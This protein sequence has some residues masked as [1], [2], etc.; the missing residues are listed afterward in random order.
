MA[1]GGEPLSPLKQFCEAMKCRSCDKPPEKP[2]TLQC[3]HTFCED[4]LGRYVDTLPDERKR[5]LPCPTCGLERDPPFD[6]HEGI[7]AGIPTNLC[8]ANFL[9]HMKKEAACSADPGESRCDRCRR[10][11]RPVDTFCTVCRCSLCDRCVEDHQSVPDTEDHVLVP[12]NASTGQHGRWQCRKHRMAAVERCMTQ[13]VF[14]CEKCEVVM[15]AASRLT[16]HTGHQTSTA[17]DAYTKQ[18]HRAR[19]EQQS[20]ETE[21][22]EDRFVATMGE[23]ENLK[24]QLLESK[25][26]TESEIDRKT[27]ALHEAL[28][29]ENRR[30]KRAA[31][32]IFCNKTA[33]CDQ[34]MQELVEI[35]E[36]FSH[37]LNITQ[38]ALQVGEA[39][40]VLFLEGMLIDSLKRLSQMYCNY[41]HKLCEDRI[42][43]FTENCRTNFT[44]SI[45]QVTPDLFIPGLHDRLVDAQFYAK[46]L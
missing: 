33:K 45:G 9:R 23:L 12:K 17:V 35:H 6:G 43:H 39:E 44:G 11:G 42:V 20:N 22:I 32:E 18:G 7:V 34:Q 46:N 16:E 28:D 29:E 30:V 24:R 10:P 27:A 4:C 14:Y 15:C 26:N 2:K 36:R 41:D 5:N 8:F 38:S 13:V 40:D 3:L 31:N 25:K 37:S 19:I 1:T 21:Q